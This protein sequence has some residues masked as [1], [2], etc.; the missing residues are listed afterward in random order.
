M[1]YIYIPI[2]IGN[3]RKLNFLSL[4]FYFN[5][6]ISNVYYLTTRKYTVNSISE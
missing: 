5:F 6:K 3:K 2:G 1:I 4:K